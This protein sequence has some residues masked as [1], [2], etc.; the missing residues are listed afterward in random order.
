MKYRKNFFSVDIYR[1]V[2]NEG[3][4]D[5]EGFKRYL[6]NKGISLD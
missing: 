4:K 5:L 3:V 2:I 6:G 1:A